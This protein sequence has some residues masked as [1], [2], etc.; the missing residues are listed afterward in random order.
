MR[1]VILCPGPSLAR[2][3]AAPVG[4]DLTIGV[5]RAAEAVACDWLA[6]I[7]CGVVAQMP[8][9]GRP[10]LFTSAKTWSRALADGAAPSRFEE[11]LLHEE[12]QFTTSCPASPGWKTFSITTAL[13]LAEF[14]QATEIEL[15]GADW[16]GVADWDGSVPPEAA[17][18][19]SDARWGAEKH[20]FGHVL[21]WLEKDCGIQ[22]LHHRNN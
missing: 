13:V 4:A 18:T 11:I 20:K 2:Y 16:L 12:I 22:V 21:R 9:K 8:I 17:H 10:A 3:L 14:L 19:R 6:A 5:N 1:A 7:D 15:F